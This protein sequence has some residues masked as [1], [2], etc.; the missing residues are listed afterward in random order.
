MRG[1]DKGERERERERER[2]VQVKFCFVKGVSGLGLFTEHIYCGWLSVLL[3]SQTHT[4][5]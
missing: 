5:T 2:V 4:V 1:N 3:D